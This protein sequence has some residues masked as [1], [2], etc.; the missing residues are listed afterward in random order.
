LHVS[1]E[2]EVE[3]VLPDGADVTTYLVI[4][5]PPVLAGLVHDT[6][7]LALPALACTARAAEGLVDEP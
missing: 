2:V 4:G 5:E 1:L 3:H 6:L 7:A